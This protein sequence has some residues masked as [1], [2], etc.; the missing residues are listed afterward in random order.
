MFEQLCSSFLKLLINYD[1]E[2]AGEDSNNF[3]VREQK[4]QMISVKDS[5]LEFAGLQPIQLSWL[6]QIN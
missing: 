5:I 3:L 6:D 2:I 1:L 4:T